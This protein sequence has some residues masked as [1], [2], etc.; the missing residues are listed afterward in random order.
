MSRLF[1]M[2]VSVGI[3]LPSMQA[4]PAGSSGIAS[5][6]KA[7]LNQDVCRAMTR[8]A[9]FLV[10]VQKPAKLGAV[11][12]SWQVNQG[13]VSGNVAGLAAMSLLSAHS[14]SGGETYLAA[15]RRYAD[16]LVTGKGGWTLTN[17]P[18]K[19]DVQFLARLASATGET[20]Y[21]DTA[22]AAFELIRGRSPDGAREV[23][24]I[25][26]G[27]AKT[28]ALLGFD[29]ALGIRAATAVS[30][31]RYAYQMADAVLGRLS[32]WYLPKKNPR[33]SL[34]SGAAL[35]EALDDLDAGHYRQYI[36]RFRADLQK[37]QQP[38]GAWLSNETQPS[39]YAVM[40]LAG[41]NPAQRAAGQK[42]IDWIKSTM[43]KKGSYAVYND[44]MPEPFVGQVIS[45]V[46]A[47]ALSALALACKTD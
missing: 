25:A 44:F 22:L 41:G 7:N 14:T 12:W 26:S 6:Y 28:P 15:A 31:R 34:V 32:D 8:A 18:Y 35:T 16:G 9:D 4:S 10:A 23:A 1:F 24:R 43:L 19:A 3:C 20:R 2:I 5:Q 27:R 38:N 29:A 46:H 33:F 42:G 40:A 17:L 37:A 36:E 30:A 39:A 45:E 21:R 11:G 47:E 13:P